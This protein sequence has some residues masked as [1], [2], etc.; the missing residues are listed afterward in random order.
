MSSRI[1]LDESESGNRVL[2]LGAGDSAAP[3]SAQS[4]ID[5]TW[6]NQSPDSMILYL[7]EEP[8]IGDEFTYNGVEWRI[9]DYRDGWI[10]TLLVD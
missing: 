1:E 8:G 2:L 3:S 10:A 5:A 6:E 7:S 9:I 4:L